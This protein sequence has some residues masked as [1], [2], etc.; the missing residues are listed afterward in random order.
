MKPMPHSFY[1]DAVALY[2]GENTQ[3]SFLNRLEK[4]TNQQQK[5]LKKPQTKRVIFLLEQHL[6][7][8]ATS[9]FP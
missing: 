8:I 1:F 3:L 5:T 4:T 9:E 6:L 7:F 2:F